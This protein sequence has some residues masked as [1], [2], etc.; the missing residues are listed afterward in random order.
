MH[1]YLLKK[2]IKIYQTIN[3]KNIN[4]IIACQLNPKTK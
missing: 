4:R 1:L 2:Q 3:L